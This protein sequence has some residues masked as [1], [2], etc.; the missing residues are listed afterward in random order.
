MEK[1]KKT[2]VLSFD[3]ECHLSECGEIIDDNVTFD[4]LGYRID[5]EQMEGKVSKETTKML[6]CHEMFLKSVKCKETGEEITECVDEFGDTCP[7]EDWYCQ[8]WAHENFVEKKLKLE[9]GKRYYIQSYQVRN[10]GVFTKRV[11]FKIVTDGDFDLNKLQLISENEFD[12]LYWDIYH[13]NVEGIIVGNVEP[14]EGLAN[15]YELYYD[16][17]KVKANKFKVD[18]VLR[19]EAWMAFMWE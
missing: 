6:F 17:K 15:P 11:T 13:G 2:W 3:C 7:I 9:C 10:G 19:G 8:E 18:R 16:G 5:F 12:Y 14:E 1:N 4:D